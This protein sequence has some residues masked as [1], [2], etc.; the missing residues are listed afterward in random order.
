MIVLTPDHAVTELKFTEG[1][2]GGVNYQVMSPGSSLTAVSGAGTYGGNAALTASL[3]NASGLPLASAPVNFYL[4]NGSTTTMVGTGTT[5][6]SGVA[7]LPGVSLS[8]YF[9][10]TYSITAV[11]A[12]DST[13]ARV[14]P[15][16]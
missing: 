2:T 5:N 1:G 12:G 4:T 7:I 11:F 13:R 3:A 6:D 15:G 9:A 14:S 16:H 8:G 10:G